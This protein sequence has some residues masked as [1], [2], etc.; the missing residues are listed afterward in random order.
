[1]SVSIYGN[2]QA[3]IQVVNATTSSTTATTS[4]SFVT[5]GFSASI[6][7]QST[8][9]KILVITSLQG[10]LSQISGTG[11]LYAI[12]QITRNGTSIAV[13]D[14]ISGFVSGGNV[15]SGSNNSFTFLDSPA[16]TSAITYTC[17][18]I[19]GRIGGSSGSVGDADSNIATT[20]TPSITL[21]EIAG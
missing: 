6:T 20:N 15:A 10:I 5:T 14:Q 13:F 3:V 11:Y 4:T 17:Q 9:S 8:T 7:P 18:Y 1:M 19:F 2:G 16:T 21:I 12:E